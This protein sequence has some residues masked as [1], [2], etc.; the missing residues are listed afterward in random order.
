MELTSLDRLFWALALAGH[1][2]LLGVL[3]IRH[4]AASFPVFTA[5]ISTNILR[6]V[7]LYG[8]LRFG[9]S[10][11]YFYTYWTLAVFDVA[12][13]LGVVYELSTHLFQPLGAW[14]PDVRRS[15]LT[16][17]GVSL[18]IAVGLTWLASPPT[19]TLRMG[20]VIRGNFF[21]SVLMSEL[22]VA[23]I[24][25]SV[26]MGL[27]WRTPVARIAQGL[28]TY[29]IFGVLTESAHSYFGSDVNKRT[30]ESLSHVRISLY[31]ACVT[32]WSVTLALR[33]P[34]PKKM[35]A[36]LHAELRALQMRAALMLKSLRTV[37]SAS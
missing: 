30:F 13:Q 10:E 36:Q 7:V 9:S 21:S 16:L 24:V 20:I 19:R 3:L 28:G 27:P 4:R 1:C 15:F 31:L 14:A 37:G 12:L 22:F 5:L 34:E 35:P 2:V 18:L 8:T 17:A 6:S 33:E 26:T 25:L 29:S 11:N 32:Y 23:M